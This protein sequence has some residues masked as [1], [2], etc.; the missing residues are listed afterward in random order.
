M[1]K[2]FIVFLWMGG[3]G[4]AKFSNAMTSEAR[5]NIELRPHAFFE[6]LI[7]AV[8]RQVRFVK[9]TCG[10]RNF[11]FGKTIIGLPFAFQPK[12]PDFFGKW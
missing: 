12:F 5:D 1:K 2:R 8:D 6:S 9:A 4:L 11:P 3:N 10:S 7:F